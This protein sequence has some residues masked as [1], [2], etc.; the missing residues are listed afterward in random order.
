LN[1]AP[2]ELRQEHQVFDLPSFD[3]SKLPSLDPG[4]GSPQFPTILLTHVPLYRD[5]G[6]PC[7]PLRER[8]PPSDPPKGQTAP[9]IPD[10]RNA[11]PV[12]RGY[13]YQNVLSDSDSNRLVDTI[14]DVVSVFSGDDHD[15]CELVH[16]P[17]KNNAR[18]ITVKSMSWAM[19][20]RRPGFLMLSMWN[21]VD[22]SGA[23]IGT[24]TAGHGATRSTST[25]LESHFCFLPDQLGIFIRYLILLC[26]TLASLL[27]R[28][29]L[30]PILKLQPLAPQPKTSSSS[31]DIPLLP[32]YAK[33]VKREP[34][35]S[36]HRFSNSST[37]STTS[38]GNASLAPRSTAARTRSISPAPGSNVSYGY[39]LPSSQA[40]YTPPG[41]ENENINVRVYD[42]DD[43][44]RGKDSARRRGDLRKLTPVQ[45]VVREIWTSVCRVAWPVTLWYLW[46]V[47]RG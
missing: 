10:E 38:N 36:S 9:V 28:A 23:S 22:A 25:T 8:W 34:E 15:Y 37:S 35:D 42:D 40:R 45:V 24:H 33:D 43:W 39:G 13:Q 47:W 32:T 44:E 5:P 46:L 19:G 7:G 14:G 41:D 27:A 12:A 16:P 6:T 4:E 20:V 31:S 2:S 1:D 26:F 18:E 21:P 30:V 11:I 29:I 17:S 3:F